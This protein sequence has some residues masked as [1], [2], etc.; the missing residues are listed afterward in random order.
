M[1]R[2]Q[3][4]N[5]SWIYFILASFTD[6]KVLEQITDAAKGVR[7]EQNSFPWVSFLGSNLLITACFVG[8]LIE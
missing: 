3:T 8:Q 6:S 4:E 1:Y 2:F 5:D 7:E